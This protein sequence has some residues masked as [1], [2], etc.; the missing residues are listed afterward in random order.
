MNI[1][2]KLFSTSKVHKYF[3]AKQALDVFIGIQNLLQG[4]IDLLLNSLGAQLNY[5]SR[6]K[7]ASIFHALS[8]AIAR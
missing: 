7:I 8:Y 2:K 3:N 5:N 6:W 4:P 1:I